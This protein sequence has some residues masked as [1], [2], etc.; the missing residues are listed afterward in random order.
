M[1]RQE[2][3]MEA[4]RREA[5]AND[6]VDAQQLPSTFLKTR[7]RAERNARKKR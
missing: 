2:R 4:L 5:I 1:T 6:Y 3:R 7:Q